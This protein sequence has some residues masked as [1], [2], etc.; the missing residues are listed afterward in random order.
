MSA[1]LS[2]QG[3]LYPVGGGGGPATL[4][5]VTQTAFA[6]N[7]TSHPVNMPAAVN[8]G[9][10]LVLGITMRANSGQDLTSAVTTP[11][12]WT[13][14]G[15]IISGTGGQVETQYALFYKIASG[16]E[17]GTTVDVQTSIACHAAAQVHRVS[18]ATNIDFILSS[19]PSTSTIL[20]VSLSISNGGAQTVW[21]AGFGS[22]GTASPSSYPG[23]YP[24]ENTTTASGGSNACR[25]ISASATD[26]NSNRPS[27]SFTMSANTNTARFVIAAW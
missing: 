9:N 13:K 25:V 8:P 16:S 5:S 12:G 4:L 6:S 23:A 10:M 18:G 21:I 15:Q 2:H 17:G 20:I 22:N 27:G 19:Q 3:L 24:D 11:A 26:T 7:V 14:L 1:I